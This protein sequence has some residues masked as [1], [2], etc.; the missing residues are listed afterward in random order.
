MIW[1]ITAETAL[2][3]LYQMVLHVKA[4]R[5]LDKDFGLKMEY[6]STYLTYSICWVGLEIIMTN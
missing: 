1:A 2:M 6:V 5:V 3:N 4:V